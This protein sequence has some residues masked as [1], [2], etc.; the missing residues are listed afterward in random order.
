LWIDTKTAEIRRVVMVG[1]VQLRP[2]VTEATDF[3]LDLMHVDGY[4]VISHAFWDYDGLSGDFTFI[5]YAFPSSVAG[6]DNVTA[7]PVLFN[8]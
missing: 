8:P 1:L 2:L 6:F 5:N 3:T 4:N 7:A